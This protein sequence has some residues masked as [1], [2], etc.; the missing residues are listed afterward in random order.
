MKWQWAL[1]LSA[2]L[3]GRA[4]AQEPA[5][6]SS[7]APGPSSLSELSAAPRNVVAPAQLPASVPVGEV[8]GDPLAAARATPCDVCA[9]PA[10]AG[11]TG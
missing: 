4:S 9:R 10:G 2:L 5:P 1:F 7:P 3:A 8:L 6:A 11:A